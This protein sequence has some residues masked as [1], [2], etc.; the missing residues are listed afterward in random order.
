MFSSTVN[1]R[2]HVLNFFV[3]KHTHLV[4]FRDTYSR[5]WKSLGI[6]A[7]L[8]YI[9]DPLDSVGGSKQLYLPVEYVDLKFEEDFAVRLGKYGCTYSDP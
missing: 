9:W 2:S 8:S 4:G 3:L 6:V 7:P 1:M 5:L